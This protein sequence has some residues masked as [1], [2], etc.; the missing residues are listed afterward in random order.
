MAYQTY[1]KDPD[2]VLDYKFDFAALRNGRGTEDYLASGETI[3]SVTVTSSS[4]DLVVDSYALA[5]SDSSVICWLSGGIVNTSYLVTAR[6]TTSESRT[7]DRT[8]QIQVLER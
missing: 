4:G 1:E 2:A 5:D 3:L 8:I 6:I 7:D